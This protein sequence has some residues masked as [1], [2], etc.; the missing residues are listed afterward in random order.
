MEAPFAIFAKPPSS[1][2]PNPP[3]I[4]KAADRKDSSTEIASPVISLSWSAITDN[5]RP[6]WLPNSVI[7]SVKTSNLAEDRKK[8]KAALAANTLAANVA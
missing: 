2:A 7:P 5:V 8:L 4:P 6:D 1:S 3:D